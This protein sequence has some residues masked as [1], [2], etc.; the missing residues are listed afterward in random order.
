MGE[1][2]LWTFAAPPCGS[3]LLAGLAVETSKDLFAGGSVF[4]A[5][6]ADMALDGSD[7]F[8]FVFGGDLCVAALEVMVN[9]IVG[10][11][12][13]GAVTRSGPD[14]RGEADRC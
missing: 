12:S 3:T 14:H 7:E 10:P 1:A 6:V 4:A 8:I 9:V 2:A 5:V 11:R 13:V